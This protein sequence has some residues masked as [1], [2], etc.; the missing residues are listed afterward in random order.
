MNALRQ[1]AIVCDGDQDLMLL[2]IKANG[3][4][5][6]R[7]LAMS[8]QQQF[9]NSSDTNTEITYTFPLPY[10]A[11]LMGV[12]VELNGK[13]LK[14]EVAARRT[15]RARYEEAI[16]EGNSSI[17][18]ERNPDHSYT[19]ELGNLMAREECSITVRYAQ[20]LHLDHGQIRLML[21]TTIA[22]R[23]G[24]PITQ[25]GMQPH[26]TTVT[27]ITAEYPFDI[28]LTLYGDLAKA[29]VASP[30]HKTGYHPNGDEL[31]VRLA[32]RGSL[33]RDF[34]L[35]VSDLQNQSSAISCLDANVEGQTALMANFSPKLGGNDA[36]A[37]SAKILVD[38]SGSMAGDSIAAARSALRRI[39]EGLTTEDKF[40]L[41]RFGST[42]EHRSRG[43]W[44]GTAQAKTSAKRWIDSVDADLGGT[45]MADA[46][47]STIA[48]SHGGQSDILLITDGEIQGIDEVIQVATQSG[49]RVFVVAIGASPA[50][51]HLRRLSGATGGVCDFVAPGEDVEPAV[52]RMF[53]RMRTSRASNLRV[54]WPTSFDV[55]W[56]Q[57]LPDF[58]FA[59]DA[60]DVYAF[61]QSQSKEVTVGVV[62]LWG[63]IGDSDTEVLL[64]EADMAHVEST[65][66]T[67]ARVTAYARY[68]EIS[69]PQK[70]QRTSIESSASQELAVQY[71]LVTGETNFVLVH[72]RDASQKAL[73]MPEAHKVP[74]MMP[75]GW[76]GTGAV[77]FS[78]KQDPAQLSETENVT[79]SSVRFSNKAAS[80]DYA[81]MVTPTVWRS[82]RST[83][84]ESADTLGSDGM[85]DYEIPAFLRK[86]ADAPPSYGRHKATD[87]AGITPAEFSNWLNTHAASNWPMSYEA[88]RNIGL[89]LAI[90]EWLEIEVGKGRNEAEVVRAFI[91]VVLGFKLASGFGV[92][93]AVQTIKGVIQ[94]ANQ[95][96]ATPEITGAIRLGLQGLQ[97]SNW[98]ESVANFPA[99]QLV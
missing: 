68:A 95:T 2:G 6:G 18:L 49:H 48:I 23:Y 50:E 26:Q 98:P 89:G 65:V 41:S 59:N 73:E 35:T 92:R 72:E 61:A 38:C 82:N 47:T 87:D 81:S 86:K 97:A 53:S 84:T 28:S 1:A 42:V 29:N 69:Q 22:P 46:L 32:Q 16:S 80:A 10:G 13:Q 55:K 21:P 63:C 60:L 79:E 44:G 25:G 27:D 9:R 56:S 62:R 15:A 71:Q 96:A 51:V 67:L 45:E 77:Q 11:V 7:L 58:A 20:V 52:I 54:E 30:S 76:G 3:A 57:K 83:V 66:N 94:P 33:D 74:Q 78:R 17:M 24:N 39:V 90:C 37:V 40:S 70:T 36:E 5:K 64:A 99:A 85:D 14:G 19:L 12:D 4:I 93:K 34:I 8:L 91:A 75:A 43:M 31:V 88:L